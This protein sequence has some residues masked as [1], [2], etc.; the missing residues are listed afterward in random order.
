[1]VYLL[2]DL[3]NHFI[4]SKQIIKL[5]MLSIIYVVIDL[6]AS[7]VKITKDRILHPKADTVI[8]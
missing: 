3:E 1:M 2:S 7:L 8:C 4:Y 5:K 6:F